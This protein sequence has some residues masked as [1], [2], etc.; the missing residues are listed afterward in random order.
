MNNG[1]AFEKF[2]ISIEQA[3]SILKKVIVTD[4]HKLLQNEYVKILKRFLNYSGVIINNFF[5]KLTERIHIEVT[6]FIFN[7]KT[8]TKI[9]P[10]SINQLC[11]PM[12]DDHVLDTIL[13]G[14]FR[15]VEGED[16]DDEA[17]IK[18]L[19]RDLFFG[20]ENFDAPKYLYRK[21]IWIKIC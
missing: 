6:P 9:L 19:D 3:T 14:K 11:F 12:L 1:L 10:T 16:C 4:Y 15:F 13:K 8:A 2:S 18:D 7:C 21:L 5:Y 20:E 17:I